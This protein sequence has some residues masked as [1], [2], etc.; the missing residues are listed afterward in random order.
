LA[1]YEG[2]R[3]RGFFIKGIFDNNPRKINEKIDNIHVY[4]VKDM[5]KYIRKWHIEI[6]IIAVPENSAQRVADIM[7]AGGIK[8]ILNFSPVHIKLSPEIKLK[9]LDLSVELES[10]TYYLNL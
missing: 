3:K 9:N 1:Q 8:S 10:L 5:G 2:F 6:G 7:I 4:D